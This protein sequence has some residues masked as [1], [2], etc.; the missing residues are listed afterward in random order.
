M[1]PFTI[2]TTSLCLQPQLRLW[3][4]DCAS[5]QS[6]QRHG[7]RMSVQDSSRQV[8][9]QCIGFFHISRDLDQKEGSSPHSFLNPQLHHSEVSNPPDASSLADTDGNCQV[10]VYPQGHFQSEVATDTPDSVRFSGAPGDPEQLCLGRA[11]CYRFLCRTTVPDE[12]RAPRC[13]SSEVPYWATPLPKSVSTN[14]SRFAQGCHRN[15]YI[16]RGAVSKYPDFQRGA[17]LSLV[18]TFF[19]TILWLRRPDLVCSSRGSSH[20]PQL[21]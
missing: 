8:F 19:G 10:R 20:R 4:R 16:K 14:T 18:L 7:R 21:I 11:Q 6:F 9:R 3:Y 2:S 12:V 17:R 5:V 15:S 13:R 1:H